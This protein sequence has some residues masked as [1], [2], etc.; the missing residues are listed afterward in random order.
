[1]KR[2][3]SVQYY[4][5]WSHHRYPWDNILRSVNES[6]GCV[7]GLPLIGA[8]EQYFNNGGVINRD[9]IGV[10]HWCPGIPAHIDEL[11][12]NGP[13]DLDHFIST[14]P[15]RLSMA[16]CRGIYVFSRSLKS[17]LDQRILPPVEALVYPTTA[18][19]RYFSA[20]EY[21][22]NSDRSIVMIGHWL[23]V[24]KSI[25]DLPVSDMNKIW[26][27]GDTNVSW[28]KGVQFEGG[29]APTGHT[30]VCGYVDNLAFDELL[31]RNIG[32]LHLYS[33]SVNNA[34]LDCLIRRTPLLVNR[35]EAV[36]E[37]LG[38]DYP[39]YFSD[40]EEAA[41]KLHDKKLILEAHD[42]MDRNPVQRFI[43]LKYFIESIANSQ[44]YRSI[45]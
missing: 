41:E 29:C 21:F 42:H 8:V 44:I 30:Q 5:G 26:L 37:Y 9:W 25:F 11:Y 27:R 32:F 10:M 2:K 6:L 1:M 36:E 16:T 22:G 35:L 38:E 18:P 31:S 45:Q 39:L 24:F 40:L 23:R 7:N 15:F 12:G 43:G 13:Y 14:E 19:T 34:I 20:P 28:E 4:T 17:W 3:I 33:S